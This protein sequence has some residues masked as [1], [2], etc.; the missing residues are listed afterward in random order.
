MVLVF[1]VVL[2]PS[3]LLSWLV[4]TPLWSG[5]ARTVCGAA[6]ATIQAQDVPQLSLQA[7][8]SLM[9]AE[10]LLARRSMAVRPSAYACGWWYL[11]LYLWLSTCG[12]VLTQ[13]WS[14]VELGLLQSTRS[15]RRLVRDLTVQVYRS[16]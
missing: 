1:G 16:R 3:W 4:C 13:A 11:R 9:G 6:G 7:G 8:E 5:F 12:A 2:E 14:A 10:V 15:F